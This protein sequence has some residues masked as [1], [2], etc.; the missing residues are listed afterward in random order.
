MRRAPA[1]AMDEQGR[2]KN[3][4]EFG[5]HPELRKAED[6]QWRKIGWRLAM[7]EQGRH[8]EEH[9]GVW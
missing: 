1:S 2:R 7:D 9:Q 8:Q 5:E 6:P 4:K 3:I